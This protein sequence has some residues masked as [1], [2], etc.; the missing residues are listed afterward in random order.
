MLPTCYPSPTTTQTITLIS[1]CTEPFMGESDSHSSHWVGE[2]K[3]PREIIQII[4]VE[5]KSIPAILVL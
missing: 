3:S 5:E 2:K 4:N 1:L